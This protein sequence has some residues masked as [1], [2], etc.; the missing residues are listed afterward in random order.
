MKALVTGAGG[1]LG[2]ALVQRA[3]S[4][5][6]VIG[7]GSGDLD[8][9]DRDAVLA[10]IARVKPDVILNAAAYTAVDLAESEPERARA[11]NDFGVS[12][13]VAA[14]EAVRARVVHISTDFVFDGTRSRAYAPDDETA[15][16]GVYGVTKLAGERHLRPKDLCVR[17]A[18]VYDAEGKNFVRTMLRLMGERAE[19]GVVADQIGSPT[20]AMDL[21]DAVWGLTSGGHAG[22]F[23][24]T[25]SGVASWYDFAVAIRDEGVALAL[26]D[27][28]AARVTPILTADYPTPAKR[29][30]FSVLDTT[31]TAQA[32]GK[33]APHWR[34]SLTRVLEQIKAND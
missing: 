8:V 21:A 5:A 12:H 30:A 16:L 23:H 4:A 32:L 33:A 1:Q 3:P 31:K 24:F 27:E 29:P 6:E 13:L 18:W 7:L 28:D 34:H 10:T 19:L 14:A 15:P 26:L 22:L 17:T 2:R 9:A 25:G 11:V 20:S